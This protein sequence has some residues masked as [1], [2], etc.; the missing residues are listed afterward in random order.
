MNSKEKIKSIKSL[1][2]EFYH[3]WRCRGTNWSK[4]AED[5]HRLYQEYCD[6][7]FQ[8]L[9]RLEKLEQENNSLRAF[10]GNLQ[11]CRERETRKIEKLEKKNQVLREKV[12]HFKNVKNRMRRNCKFYEK[13]N[14]KL[15]KVIEI[16]EKRLDAKIKVCINGGC[17]ISIL[18]NED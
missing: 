12:N 7:I 3:D 5:C 10:V 2:N 18:V 1:I 8:D 17:S 14:T 13:E 16:L 11:F 15:K 9:E 4:D 6:D